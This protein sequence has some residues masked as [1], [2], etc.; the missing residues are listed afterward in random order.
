MKTP[1]SLSKP[2]TR[3]E[4]EAKGLDY[5]AVKWVAVWYSDLDEMLEDNPGLQKNLSITNRDMK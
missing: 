3:E 5:D 2:W 1:A 4:I